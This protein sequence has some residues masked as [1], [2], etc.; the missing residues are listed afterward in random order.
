VVILS[1]YSNWPLNGNRLIKITPSAVE[2][3]ELAN[4]R[5]RDKKMVADYLND[6]EIFTSISIEDRG[7]HNLL[8]VFGLPQ[9]EEFLDW[10]REYCGDCIWYCQYNLWFKTPVEATIFKLRWL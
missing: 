6:V 7:I 9:G 4:S 2:Y 3:G 10:L 5:S 1:N 8:T